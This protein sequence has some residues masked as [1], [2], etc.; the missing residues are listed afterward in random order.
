MTTEP[1]LNPFLL[2]NNADSNLRPYL[3]GIKEHQG[4]ISTITLYTGDWPVTSISENPVVTDYTAKG[5]LEKVQPIQPGVSNETVDVAPAVAQ[6]IPTFGYKEGVNGIYF[7]V[8]NNFSLL[9]VSEAKDQIIKLHQNFGSSWNLF[10]FGD[11]PQIYTFRGIFL[12]T[13]EYPYYQEFMTMYD[14]FLGGRKCVE[15]GFKM[16][17][18]YDGKIIGGYLMG[19][20]TGISADQPHT[21]SFSFTVILTDENYMRENARVTANNFTGQSGFNRMN[22]GHR[23]I[24]QYPTLFGDYQTDDSQAI[25]QTDINTQ[26]PGFDKTIQEYSA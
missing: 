10:F 16:K 21:K 18:V 7:G 26:P 9:D 11:T 20:N 1:I 22:N 6:N 19:I 13:W 12:D 4:S 5:S 24:R 2:E 17:M 23:V 14:K 25:T 3:S 8:F 15:N